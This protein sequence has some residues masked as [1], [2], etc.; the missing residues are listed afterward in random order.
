MAT[1][2]PDYSANPTSPWWSR[3]LF[4]VSSQEYPLK[5]DEIPLKCQRRQAGY[6][7]IGI[8]ILIFFT[9]ISLIFVG[10]WSSRTRFTPKI[11]ED[12]HEDLPDVA[13]WERGEMDTEA[14]TLPVYPLML[15]SGPRYQR[16]EGRSELPPVLCGEGRKGCGEAG[17]PVN[18]LSFM[19]YKKAN[20]CARIFAV[21]KII[22]VNEPITLLQG[23]CAVPT[24][25]AQTVTPFAPTIRTPV[26]LQ[27]MVDAVR[28]VLCAP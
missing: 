16:I 28:W 19:T 27:K 26:T 1:S 21:R 23:L 2:P 25:H 6:K 8:A 3:H 18:F 12:D 20:L 14:S 17:Q 13:L 10:L 4:K 5:S 15:I 7:K 24:G 22:A 9:I 11:H